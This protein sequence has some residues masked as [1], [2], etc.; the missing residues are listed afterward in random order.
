MRGNY[1]LEV[2]D[3]RVGNLSYF[4]NGTEVINQDVG[5]KIRGGVSR[6][7]QSKSLTV[8]ARSDYG[9]SDLSYKFF[10]K[11][12][13]TSFERLTLSNSGGDF[14]S[15]MF[16]DALLHDLS[17]ELYP[18]KE[19][20]QPT[21]AFVNGE[22]W[23]ILNMRDRYDDNYFKRVYNATATDF[24]ENDGVVKE[25]DAVN[26]NA[27]MSYLNANSLATQANYDY[28]K[29]QLDPE[30][31]TD[32]FISNVYFQNEDW[33]NNNMFLW[34]NKIAAYNPAAPPGLDGR[35]RYMF[36]DMDNSMSFVFGDYTSN[37]L[38]IATSVNTGPNFLN[39][40][41]STLVLRKLL[42][43]TSFKNDFI[44]RFADLLNTSFLTSRTVARLNEMAA[45]VAVEIGGHV[46]RWKAPTSVNTFNSD[47]EYES[48]F[49]TDRP[50]LQRDHIRSV[51][52]ITSNINATLK[53]VF[54]YPY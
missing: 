12:P 8:Y 27:L 38:A 1:Y 41:Y 37:S 11:L 23:G 33:P 20:Y 25:G 2:N 34:R 44:N 24:L 30:N 21:I 35:W 14:F 50:S 32:Y 52:S 28:V 46:S 42:T 6:R 22:Y 49:L 10:S 40:S 26:Y 48:D 43:N 29:T 31:V 7:F 51:F 54:K 53:Y 45:V 5:F 13:Y 36:H 17:T 4:V 3:E 39:P 16:R 47:L 15:T 9:D 18:E 19:A